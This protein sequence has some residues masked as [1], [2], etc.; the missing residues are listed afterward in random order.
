MEAGSVTVRGGGLWKGRSG[1]GWVQLLIHFLVSDE[2][3]KGYGAGREQGC[4]TVTSC[5]HPPAPSPS[6]EPGEPGM[7]R[8]H[9]SKG[10]GCLRNGRQL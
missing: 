6:G 10:A 2:W 3:T 9:G 1:D 8:L 7:Q 5:L 4:S